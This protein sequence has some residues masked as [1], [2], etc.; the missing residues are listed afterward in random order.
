[1]KDK[2]SI[3]VTLFLNILLSLPYLNKFLDT[4]QF[5]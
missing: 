1:M 3:Y 2:E 4:T 5:R